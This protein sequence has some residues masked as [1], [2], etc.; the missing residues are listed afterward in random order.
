MND[1]DSLGVEC[2]VLK[3]RVL[4]G[5]SSKVYGGICIFSFSAYFLFQS[6]FNSLNS[7][8]I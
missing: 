8:P 5:L 1:I 3:F 2:L 6:R 4:D 7:I